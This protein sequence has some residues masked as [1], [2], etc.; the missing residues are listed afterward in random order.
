[1]NINM[2]DIID[3]KVLSFLLFFLVFFSQTLVLRETGGEGKGH[4]FFSDIY[5]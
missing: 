1:M 2:S 4:L 5:L 3:T